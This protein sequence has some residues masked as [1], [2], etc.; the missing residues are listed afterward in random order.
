MLKIA[1]HYDFVKA[2]DFRAAGY[3]NLPKFNGSHPTK[4]GHMTMATKIYNEVGSWLTGGAQGAG[5]GNSGDVTG[6]S[7]ES[8]VIGF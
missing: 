2:V 1:D 4:A 6:D 7:S 3:N 8:T 5:Y